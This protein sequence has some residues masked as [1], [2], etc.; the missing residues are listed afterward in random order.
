MSQ[1]GSRA[2]H[3]IGVGEQSQESVSAAAVVSHPFFLPQGGCSGGTA[4]SPTLSTR[5]LD[6]GVT[7]DDGV[8]TSPA[9]SVA[10]RR[11][12][13]LDDSEL[14]GGVVQRRDELGPVPGVAPAPAAV[15]STVDIRKSRSV[16]L[17]LALSP[18]PAP[19]SPLQALASSLRRGPSTA[20][21][22]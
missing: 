12:D 1:S 17:A 15:L 18:A 2:V 21:P 22:Q 9:A 20:P 14:L 5:D 4:A 13:S 6:H 8:G 11:K 19:Q 10:P 3:A 7:I 16:L